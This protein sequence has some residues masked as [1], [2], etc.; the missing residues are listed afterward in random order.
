MSN[1]IA[2]QPY[3]ANFQFNHTYFKRYTA[4]LLKLQGDQ[5]LREKR[6]GWRNTN[7]PPMTRQSL[8]GVGSGELCVGTGGKNIGTGSIYLRRRDTLHS[9]RPSETHGSTKTRKH[10]SSQNRG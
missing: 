1:Q 7:V 4:D 2:P 9:G 6:R 5:I 3:H 8:L 10:H